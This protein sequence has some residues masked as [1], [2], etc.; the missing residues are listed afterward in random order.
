[1]EILKLSDLIGQEIAEVRYRYSPETDEEYSVQSCTTFIKLV[2]NKIIGIPNFD[3]DEYLRYTPENLNYF[4]GNFDNGSKISY[5]AAKLLNG[6]TIVD[7]LFCYDGNEPEYDHSAYFKLSN[8]YYLTE[9][10]H[11]PVG[12]YVGLLLLNE[13]EFLKEKHRLAKL[14]IDIR[15]FL[16]NKDELL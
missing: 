13:E 8:G 4:K 12:I 15:S 14:N 11:A 16:K 5:D 3:D 6:E 9:R 2:N 7:I 1:M 10:S